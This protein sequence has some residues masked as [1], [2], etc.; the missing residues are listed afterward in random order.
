M[1]IYFV[2][3]IIFLVLIVSDRVDATLQPVQQAVE[4]IKVRVRGQENKNQSE[5]LVIRLSTNEK[6]ELVGAES[7][8]NPSRQSSR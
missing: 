2:V 7:V 8:Y 3:I 4:K 6:C 1:L 5:G